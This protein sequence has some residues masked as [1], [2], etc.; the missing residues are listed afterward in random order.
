MNS[1]IGEEGLLLWESSRSMPVTPG[2]GATGHRRQSRH[3]D[4]AMLLKLGCPSNSP[5][6]LMKV[7]IQM[8]ASE[9]GYKGPHFK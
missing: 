5:E 6:D 3:L 8:H 2:T 4:G 9:V 1:S 7:L